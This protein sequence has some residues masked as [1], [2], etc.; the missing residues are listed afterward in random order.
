MLKAPADSAMAI[1]EKTIV[2]V[3]AAVPD[4]LAN[5][6]RFTNGCAYQAGQFFRFGAGIGDGHGTGL[7]LKGQPD[8]PD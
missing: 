5:F 3:S 2:E 1:S 6:G 7:R 4:D 8:F